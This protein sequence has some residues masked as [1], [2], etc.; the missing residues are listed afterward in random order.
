LGYHIFWFNG[1]VRNKRKFEMNKSDFIN[2][3]FFRPPNSIIKQIFHKEEISGEFDYIKINNKNRI[4]FQFNDVDDIRKYHYE[5]S[6][7]GAIIFSGIASKLKNTG[8]SIKDISKDI[9]Y[10]SMYIQELQS[11]LCAQIDKVKPQLLV[12]INDRLPG[13]S[14]SLAIA[15]RLNISTKVFYWGSGMNKIIGYDNSL[16]DF[17]EWRL[18]TKQNFLKSKINNSNLSKAKVE[19]EKLVKSPSFDSRGFLKYQ[20][21]GTSVVKK[22]RLIVFYAASEHEHSPLIFRKNNSFSSQYT[23]F[24]ALQQICIELNYQLV[25]KYHPIRKNNKLFDRN[26]FFLNDWK[27][28]T[29]HPDVLQLM[30]DSSVDTYQLM[31]DADINVTWSSTIG[32]ESIVRERPTIIMGDTTWLDTNWGIHAWDVET[33]IVKTLNYNPMWPRPGSNRRPTAFQAVARTN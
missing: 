1:A 30:P 33:L 2:P 31:K 9:E 27:K 10:F 25:I 12:T 5:S 8:F 3:I 17:D 6:P 22:N 20:K 28:I 29:I 7:V 21:L 18:M 24:E 15:R 13:S 16:Y 23:A 14:L 32:I 11:R 4:N 26:K 19:I